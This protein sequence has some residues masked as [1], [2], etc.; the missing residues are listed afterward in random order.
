MPNFHQIIIP[1][2]QPKAEILDIHA[3]T[4][5]FYQEVKLRQEHEQYCQ[6]Y[7]QVAAQHQQELQQMQHD[8]N[9]LGWFARRSR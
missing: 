9:L 4:Q 2:P 1:L 5:A 6:W 8:I 7:E 3:V